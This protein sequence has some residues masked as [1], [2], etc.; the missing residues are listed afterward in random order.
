M[1]PDARPAARTTPTGDAAVPT[2]RRRVLIAGRVQAVGYRASCAHRAAEAGLG[3]WV[4]NLPDG[5]VEAV[6]EGPVPSV[7]ML[8]AWCGVGPP[9]ARVTGVSVTEEPATGETRFAIR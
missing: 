7:D 1:S 2:V 5:R 6:F 8:V 9:L 4:R 3:G